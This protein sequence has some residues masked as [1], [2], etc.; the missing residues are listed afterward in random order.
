MTFMAILGFGEKTRKI[1]KK[2]KAI[3]HNFDVKIIRAPC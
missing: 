2:V 1:N 3:D